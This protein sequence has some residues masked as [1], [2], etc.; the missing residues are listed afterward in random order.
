MEPKKV[1]ERW[2]RIGTTKY[3]PEI[4]CDGPIVTPIKLPA[5]IVLQILNRQDPGKESVVEIDPETKK[6][7]VLNRKNIFD[8]DRFGKRELPQAPIPKEHKPEP[9]VTPKVDVKVEQPV[10]GKHVEEVGV[11]TL[12]LEPVPAFTM[13]ETKVEMEM[14]VAEVES[15]EEVV[16]EAPVIPQVVVEEVVDNSEIPVT[17]NP[18]TTVNVKDNSKTNYKNTNHSNKKNRK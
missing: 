9:V 13:E 6:V 8:P 2:V 11:P 3:I 15:T 17:A 7:I 4:R 10:I 12:E 5:D 1:D 18:E 16:E 14:E